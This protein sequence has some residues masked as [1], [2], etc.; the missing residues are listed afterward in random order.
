MAIEC[1]MYGNLHES[2]KKRKVVKIQTSLCM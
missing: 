2:K 1:N